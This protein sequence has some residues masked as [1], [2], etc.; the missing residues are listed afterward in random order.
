MERDL[1]GRTNGDGRVAEGRGT[2]GGQFSAPAARAKLRAN[3]GQVKANWEWATVKVAC[4]ECAGGGERRT[5][6]DGCLTSAGP[7]MDGA[8]WSRRCRSCGARSAEARP[9]SGSWLA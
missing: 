9:M 3:Q 7:A 2:P 1:N 6:W 8:G 5:L 4:G